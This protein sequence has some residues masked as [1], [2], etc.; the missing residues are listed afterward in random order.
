MSLIVESLDF[1][2]PTLCGN[3]KSLKPFFYYA[4]RY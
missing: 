1:F 4:Q 2:N 3:G